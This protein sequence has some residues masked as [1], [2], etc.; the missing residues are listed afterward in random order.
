MLRCVIRVSFSCF[1]ARKVAWVVSCFL[2]KRFLVSCSQCVC[3][4]LFTAES[5]IAWTVCPLLFFGSKTTTTTTTNGLTMS[6]CV[7]CIS[8][9][10]SD[11][12]PSN[13]NSRGRT[14]SS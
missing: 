9:S 6:V 3:P 1:T 5:N 8:R 12:N 11:P 7:F 4:F 2:P 10:F 14:R 13:R